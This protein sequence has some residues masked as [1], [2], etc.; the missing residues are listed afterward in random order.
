M[1]GP[2]RSVAVSYDLQ[3]IAKK[4]P[5]A[6]HLDEFLEAADDAP[7]ADGRLARDGHLLLTDADGVAAEVDGPNRM[8]DEDV[9]DAAAGAIGASGWLVQ[10]SV[11]PST[12]AAWPQEL[13]IHLARATDGVVYDP[14]QDL[15]T[16]PKGFQP[17]SRETGE[18]QDRRGRTR[19]VHASPSD[20]PAL[21]GRLLELLGAHA[22]RR[23]LPKRYGPF[24]PL[25]H[26]FEGDHRADEFVERWIEVAMEWTAIA[27]LVDDAACHR[28]IG[29][30]VHAS[31][32]GTVEAGRGLRPHR[33]RLRWA[34]LRARPGLYR[35]YRRPVPGAGFGARVRLRRRL[36][37]PRR[38]RQ[39]QQHLARTTG[40]RPGPLPRADRWIGLP[41]SPTWLAWFGKPYAELVRPSVAGHIT[42]ET[43]GALFLR[44]GTEP[45]NA[46]ELADRFPPLPT[47]LVAHRIN[48]PAAWF[49]KGSF[50]LTRSAFAARGGDPADR[51]RVTPPAIDLL[52]SVLEGLELLFSQAGIVG[53]RDRVRSVRDGSER[54]VD[55]Q[56]VYRHVRRQ[57]TGHLPRPDHLALQPPPGHRGARSHGSTS[58]CA[59]SSRSA[60]WP[61]ARSREAA[62]P[63]GLG[64]ASERPLRATPTWRVMSPPRTQMHVTGM[65][66][67]TCDSRFMLDSA[68]SSAAARR[69]SLFTAPR[70]IASMR[71]PGLVAAAFSPETDP[72]T[73]ASVADVRPAIR[74]LELP[75]IRLPY[76]RPDRG[77]T[78][79]CPVCGADTWTPITWRLEGDPPALVPST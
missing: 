28:R 2:L 75:E 53:W 71:S 45:M 57:R 23:R 20:D 44:M 25:P 66:C 69:W 76:N 13:A 78:D 36:G 72:A 21:P 19:L 5:K 37:E 51:V 1:H 73:R 11:K 63:P 10:I 34:S 8:E 67:T 22:V 55:G 39:A 52:R 42:A 30:H 6:A 62:P 31:G 49:P 17:R 48:Q 64:W 7:T 4:Q 15:V 56:R 74:K 33:P 3:V 65:H 9:P 41:A 43:D 59:P 61:L 29:Q 26:R 32:A 18:V 38:D 50:T 79:R 47:N 12:D 54:R 24:E 35:A 46:D 68:T 77:P 70:H 16:W 14:Q 60:C 27:L 40:P 58:C